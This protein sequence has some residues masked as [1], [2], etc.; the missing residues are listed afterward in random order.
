MDGTVDRMRNRTKYRLLSSGHVHERLEVI[1][2]RREGESVGGCTVRVLSFRVQQSTAKPASPRPRPP[3]RVRFSKFL[4]AA[5]AMSDDD[6]VSAIESSTAENCTD[7]RTDGRTAVP[8]AGS[9]A[10]ASAFTPP[11]GVTPSVRFF[12]SPRE[13][14]AATAASPFTEPTA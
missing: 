6:C 2:V 4:L 10:V 13:V 9:P 5:P 7:G 1:A 3:Y 11:Q 8:I 14:A 12:L